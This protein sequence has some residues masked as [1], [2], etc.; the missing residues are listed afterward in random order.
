MGI[1]HIVVRAMG[2]TVINDDKYEVTI[3][4]NELV[5]FQLILISG[6]GL[7]FTGFLVFLFTNSLLSMV[8]SLVFGLTLSI[9][10]VYFFIKL[11]SMKIFTI[12]LT[13]IESPEEE[14]LQS[15]M[16]IE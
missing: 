16:K 3:K 12:D 15:V 5:F 4:I 13:L 14:D 2:S 11:K 6:L 9:I 7:L 10:I 8:S 1:Y